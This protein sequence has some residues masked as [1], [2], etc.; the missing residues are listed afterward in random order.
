MPVN[1]NFA[2]KTPISLTA[3]FCLCLAA[4]AAPRRTAADENPAAQS[5]ISPRSIE[6][7]VF[8]PQKTQP[9][10]LNKPESFGRAQ[11][12]SE[13]RVVVIDGTIKI[14]DT[15]GD[16]VE[17]LAASVSSNKMHETIVACDVV[18]FDLHKALVACGLKPSADGVELMDEI[19]DII[20]DKVAVWIEWTK[21]SVCYRIRS[22]DAFLDS[23]FNRPWE[24][25]GWVFVGSLG[26]VQ[27]PA[28]GRESRVYR[29][30]IEKSLIVNYHSPNTVLDN[31]RAI[32]AFD[33]IFL[34]NT[35]FIPP[36]GTK[37]RLIIRPVT[38]T[39]IIGG[40]ISDAVAV[41][42][43]I[44]AY[45]IKPAA[46]NGNPPKKLAAMLQH[47]SAKKKWLE[48]Q[49]LPIAKEMDS[50][51]KKLTRNILPELEALEEKLRKAVAAGDRADMKTVTD[52]MEPLLA[53]RDETWRHIQLLNHRLWALVAREESAE[54]RER[55]IGKAATALLARMDAHYTDRG[56]FVR[57]AHD[58]SLA[59]IDIIRLKGKIEKADN[60]EEKKTARAGLINAGMYRE[61]LKHKMEREEIL[62][63]LREHKRILSQIKKE[64]EDEEVRE[65]AE[66]LESYRDEYKKESAET[67]QTER[68]IR[69]AE[70]R[71]ILAELHGKLRLDE[72]NGQETAPAVM[73]EIEVRKLEENKL[74]TDIEIHVL[75]KQL[76]KTERRLRLA[77][78]G[79]DDENIIARIRAERDELLKRI[80]ILKGGPGN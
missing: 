41:I 78:E 76:V 22:E 26:Q 16:P 47:Y 48:A 29:P 57:F 2:V 28:T 69:L 20:G 3:V 17:L 56:D 62:P 31:P 24:R 45:K 58:L 35:D 49:A 9:L 65:D 38:E 23:R 33:E 25:V 46:G 63:R 40:L 73:K 52:K 18:P 4:L 61:I 44:N 14:R 32:G 13:D 77:V 15:R 19:R 59:E 71:M 21:D 6:R 27:D 74:M 68:Q 53:Y 43:K 8:G 72:L 67:Q 70:T 60:P 55:N 12:D 54:G 34:T 5:E 39:E 11:Y 64:M 7:E 42:N 51:R 66:L 80:E 79:K 36:V 1:W 75:K 10:K 30:N 50:Q 37:V